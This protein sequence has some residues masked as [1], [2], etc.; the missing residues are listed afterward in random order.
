MK[1]VAVFG[2]PGSGKS[3][4]SKALS[5]TK[6]IT[7][8]QLDSIVYQANGKPID[9]QSFDGIHDNILNSE[10]WVIDGLGPLASFRKRLDEADTLVYIDLPYPVCYWFVTKRLL[11]SLFVKPEGWPEGSSVFKG[12][13][14]SYKM[15]KL[16]PS[17]WNDEFTQS[18]NKMAKHKT[19]HIL[20]S[21]K[22]LEFFIQQLSKSKE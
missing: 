12:T 8:H 10:H 21:T 18:L 7:L 22:E 4:L 13:R 2:K 15:L 9:R 11:K 20:R 14:E 3:T 5:E 1:K 16:S 19:I 17:F 6:G